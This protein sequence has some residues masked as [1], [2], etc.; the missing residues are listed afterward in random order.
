VAKGQP[1]FDEERILDWLSAYV[2][3]EAEA[4]KTGMTVRVKGF[5]SFKVCPAKDRRKDIE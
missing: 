3:A 1:K 4:N 2:A 5:N